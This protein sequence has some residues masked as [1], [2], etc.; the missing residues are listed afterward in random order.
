MGFHPAITDDYLD[1]WDECCCCC[2]P[3]PL[4]LS[5]WPSS[6]QKQVVTW[7]LSANRVMPC[8]RFLGRNRLCYWVGIQIFHRAF[9]G[10]IQ[11]CM[12]SHPWTG[13]W[14]GVND[15]HMS[16]RVA[17]L[18]N[19]PNTNLALD[20][21]NSYELAAPIQS[22]FRGYPGI[23][24]LHYPTTQPIRPPWTCCSGLVQLWW[25]PRH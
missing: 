4:H 16:T 9:Q 2:P 18:T 15:L 12:G 13:Y 6:E 19:P 8:C 11:Q 21:S 22:N 25:V 23:P 17:R 24:T 14:L 5:S 1:V 3:N 10:F 7:D 20:S